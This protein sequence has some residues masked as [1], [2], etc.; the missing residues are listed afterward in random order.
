MKVHMEHG[1]PD[2]NCGL[3]IEKAIRFVGIVQAVEITTDPDAVTCERPGCSG[4]AQRARY[5]AQSPAERHAE[6]I[7]G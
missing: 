3:S 4:S 6:L 7:G 5:A 2:T 1:G